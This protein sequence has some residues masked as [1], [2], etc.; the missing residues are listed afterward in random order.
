MIW[1]FFKKPSFSKGEE[2]TA[3]SETKDARKDTVRLIDRDY[4]VKES[5]EGYSNT[6]AIKKTP[7]PSSK[8]EKVK[9]EGTK[10]TSQKTT[11]KKQKEPVKMTSLKKNAVIAKQISASSKTAAKRDLSSRKNTSGKIKK[12]LVFAPGE[13]CFW[14]HDGPALQSLLDLRAAFQEIIREDQYAYHA[15]KEKND[16]SQWV[17]HI[18]KDESCAKDL[19]KVKDMK[20]ALKVVEK[21]LKEYDV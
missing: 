13:V 14:V 21:H 4:K 20:A 5:P 15:N 1:R 16:F 17:L 12:E 18:L 11:V 19:L 10:S 6:M 7:A 8:S 2:R 3:S 9:K